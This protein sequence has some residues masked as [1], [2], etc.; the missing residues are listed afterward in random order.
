MGTHESQKDPRET[1]SEALDFKESIRP[2]LM[3][4]CRHQ[5]FIINM[6]QTPVPFT[7]NSKKTLEV[8]GRGTVNVRKSMNNTREA[9]FAMIVSASGKFLKPLIVFKGKPGERIEK[10]GSF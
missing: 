2:K 3:Q 1:E 4:P 8:F 6:D 9:A 7:Y 5:D 10:Q